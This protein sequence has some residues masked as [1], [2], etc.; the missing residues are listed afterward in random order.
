MTR[1]SPDDLDSGLPGTIERLRG[2]IAEAS[3]TAVDAGAATLSITSARQLFG[4]DA[5]YDVPVLAL[6]PRREGA[7]AVTL[8]VYDDNTW[9]LTAGAGPPVEFTAHNE[10][11]TALLRDLVSAV[12]RGQYVS[13][14]RRHPQ[15]WEEVGW[16]DTRFGEFRVSRL[17]GTPCDVG[18]KH[19]EPF[20]SH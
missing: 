12:V 9:V 17:S 2:I 6:T 15:A 11:P 8:E 7:A 20:L 3:R 18:R 19:Y 10:D 14:C 13:T 4:G 5:S 1:D 16:F